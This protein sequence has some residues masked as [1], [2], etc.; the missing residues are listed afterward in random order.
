ML[1][2]KWDEQNG[3][4]VVTIK[5]APTSDSDSP[6]EVFEDRAD[7]LFTGV[8]SLSRWK[9]PDIEGLHDFKGTLVHSARWDIGAQTDEAGVAVDRTHSLAAENEADEI[10]K[11]AQTT[12]QEDVKD[13][14]DK[15][16]GVIGV[17]SVFDS[18][19]CV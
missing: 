4:W 15:K 9:W 6:R 11:K 14:G 19:L 1:G 8:G 2:A 7:I 18:S 16:V 3:K 10:I 17:V 13:W 5:G 12:W